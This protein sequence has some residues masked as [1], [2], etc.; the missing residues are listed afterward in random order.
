MI[1]LMDCNNFFVSCER[2]FRPDLKKR[3]VLVL[4]SNDG[5]VVARSQETK[6]MGIPMGI[7]Y[8]EVK[9]LC[10]KE[11]V[12]LFSSNFALYRDISRRV[13]GA[14]R[15]EFDTCEVYSVDEAFFEIVDETTET[16]LMEIRA[17]IMQKTGIP[18][19][20]GIAATKTLAKVANGVAKKGTGVCILTE[21]MWNDLQNELSCGSVWG[22]GR[23]TAASLSKMKIY[24]VGDFLAQDRAFIRQS[25]GVVGERLLLE[26]SGTRV[27]TRGDQEETE[28]E[29]Y[30]STRSFGKA[31]YEKSVIESAL[32]Y[33]CAQLGEKLRRD[34]NY[35]SRMTV[36]ARA[37]RHGT[38][39]HR[40]SFVSAEL[41]IPTS[42]TTSLIKQA[43]ALFDRM[44]DV[45]I[46][47][48]KA[49]IVLKGI[50]PEGSVSGQLFSDTTHSEKRRKVDEITDQLSTRFG[51]QM[52]H[53]TII[54][55]KEKWQGA[56]INISDA[57]TT[58]WSEIAT[59]KAM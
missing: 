56:H 23:Q 45:E 25:L 16:E 9:E 5:C 24:T 57:Y 26:L 39:S 35:A 10:K 46:P 7:P 50:K 41:E 38:F 1:G 44:Y 48:K 17:R 12:T 31:I 37:S 51:K 29:S 20:I 19:S 34:G 52:V 11:K 42:D 6:D 15:S 27:Y 28:Q 4:S 55:G 30:M 40:T 21:G 49:G 47:Y 13:M 32:G 43:V 14:L 18:V 22:I 33:H 58:R 59:V 54:L 8:F 2:L 36:I 53:S 3:P